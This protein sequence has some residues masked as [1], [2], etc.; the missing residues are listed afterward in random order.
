[1]ATGCA[2]DETGLRLQLERYREAGKRARLVEQTG[3]RLVVHLD[4]HVDND[5]VEEIIAIEGACCPFFDLRW[6]PERR[7]LSVAVS[8]PDHEA[9]LDAIA[10]ALDL[11]GPADQIA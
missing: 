2:L 9:A 10:S 6:E 5:L 4:K 1:M 3:R 7:R 11:A 8:Q